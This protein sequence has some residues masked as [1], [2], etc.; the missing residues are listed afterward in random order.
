MSYYSYVRP[1]VIALVRPKGLRILDVGCAS[2]A[3]GAEMLAQGAEAV[4]G[5]DPDPV[6]ASIARGRLT[7]VFDGPVEK[8]WPWL[9]VQC[10]LNEDERFDCITCADV[11]EHMVDP[12]TVLEKLVAYLAV[13][14]RVVASIP[15]VSHRSVLL[16][17]LID[18]LWSYQDAGVLDRTHLRFFTRKTACAMLEGA[19]LVV[20]SRRPVLLPASSPPPDN[21]L[22]RCAD[23][24]CDDAVQW[25][26]VAGKKGHT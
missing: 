8:A 3:M 2:G 22:G 18:C 25:L 24:F 13:G 20:L 5:I 15:N 23:V 4:Y 11:L 26:F 16:P 21:Y 9:D 7:R 12:W 10:C 17:L 1:E 6:Q 14:G 19:G